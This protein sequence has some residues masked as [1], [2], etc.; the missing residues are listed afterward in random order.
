[1]V[2]PNFRKTMNNKPFK[3]AKKFIKN[4]SLWCLCCFTKGMMALFRK[5]FQRMPSLFKIL[6]GSVLGGL[7]R[8]LLPRRR[9]IRN[10]NRAFGE[11]YSPATKA[12]IAKGVQSNF[13]RSIQDCVLQWLQPEFVHDRVRISGLEHLEAAHAKGKGVIALG[14]HIGNFALVGA[15]L[16]RLG[17]P[18]H[19]LFKLPKDPGFKALIE[20]LPVLFHQRIISARPR[21]AAVKRVLAALEQNEIVFILADNLKKGK[22]ETSIFGRRVLTPRGP[23]SLA[24]RS[25][26]AVLPVHLIRNYEG[27][28]ELV[29]EA[30][31]P[32]EREGKLLED[33]VRN[34][35]NTMVHLEQVIRSYPDQWNWL[36][37][38]MREKREP[39][40]LSAGVGLTGR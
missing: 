8:F 26:A 4:A 40:A 39:V 24:L 2:D 38:K 22:I 21:R 34:T 32:M 33:I 23:V 15:K 10:L 36:T 7:M 5:T 28:L 27:N 31:I 12:G 3:T 9:V 20:T 35:D 18:I 16:G 1:M 14:A 17:Y 11:A 37:V 29:I 13:S 30:E 19:T 6:S 25:E